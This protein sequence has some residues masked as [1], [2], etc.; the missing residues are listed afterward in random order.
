M[1]F[2]NVPNGCV[3]GSIQTEIWKD[4][5]MCVAT[6]NRDLFKEL[7]PTKRIRRRLQR[8]LV[9]SLWPTGSTC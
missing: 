8:T 4:N 3:R 2:E 1:F 7:M 5:M 6:G 9:L